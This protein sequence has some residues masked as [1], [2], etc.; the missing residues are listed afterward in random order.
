MDTIPDNIATQFNAN[1]AQWLVLWSSK[2]ETTVRVC[3]F[4]PFTT[5]T[6]TPC[7]GD[8]RLRSM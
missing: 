3:L 5:P 1:I 4:A 2:P 8:V 6:L 7:Q